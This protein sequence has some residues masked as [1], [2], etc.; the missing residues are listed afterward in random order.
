MVNYLLSS[1]AISVL[2][3]QVECVHKYFQN[4]MEPLESDVVHT[5]FKQEKKHRD[6]VIVVFN[7]KIKVVMD[8][9]I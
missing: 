4:E 7:V 3:S 6:T 5:K 1:Q 8:L 2:E 9:F